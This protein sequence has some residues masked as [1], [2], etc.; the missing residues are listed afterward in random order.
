MKGLSII[1]H[2]DD[3]KSVQYLQNELVKKKTNA[4]FMSPKAYMK[5]ES[6]AANQPKLIIGN[7]S[8]NEITK[9]FEWLPPLYK[10]D[11][12]GEQLTIDRD[13]L[14]F[15]GIFRLLDIPFL[16]KKY[17]DR[18]RIWEKRIYIHG[19]WHEGGNNVLIFGTDEEDTFTA[20]K[21][22]CDKFLESYLESL[23]GE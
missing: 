3:M 4:G 8:K 9:Q 13:D 17:L 14:F 12:N 16:A 1:S 18:Y 2:S 20:V 21:I 15:A 5:Q 23:K 11:N 6:M 19:D 7:P 22:F 10:V